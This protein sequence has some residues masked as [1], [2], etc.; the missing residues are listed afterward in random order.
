M[1]KVA[2]SVAV[3]A[4]LGSTLWVCKTSTEPSGP[5]DLGGD[6]NIALNTVGNTF[7]NSVS[8]GSSYLSIPD[9]MYVMSNNNGFVTYRVWAD[10]SQVPS[11][12]ALLPTNR[13]D[14]AGNLNT[15]IHLKMTSEGIQDYRLA[16]SDWTKPFT[17]V[18][19]SGNVGDSYQF[20]KDGQTVTRSVTQK[21]S[22][23]D[24]P[25]GFMYIK[26]MTTEESPVV[27]LNGVTKIKYITNHKFGLVQ[28]VAMLTNGSELKITLFPNSY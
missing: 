14:T 5:N 17:I 28:I 23:D 24:F 15:T 25:Y 22:T 11:L 2:F 21:S 7:L 4:V 6:G 20:T 13:L 9:T 27:G 18:K 1:K 16:S 26:T 10:L 3:L 12:R 19:Y 8:L